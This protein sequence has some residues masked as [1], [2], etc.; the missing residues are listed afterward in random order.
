M[1]RFGGLRKKMPITNWTFA[2]GAAALAGLP[3]LSGFWSK[4]EVFAAVKS[5]SYGKDYASR[6]PI[7]ARSRPMGSSM[8]SVGATSTARCSAA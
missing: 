7:L 2:C 3:L 6:D 1:R 5:A 8:S 4:D